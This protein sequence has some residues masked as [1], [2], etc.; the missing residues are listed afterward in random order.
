[1]L[2]EKWPHI[3]R[4][5]RSSPHINYFT[6]NTRYTS[7]NETRAFRCFL[8]LTNIVWSFF[9][10]SLAENKYGERPKTLNGITRMTSIR[11]IRRFTQNRRGSR[12]LAVCQNPRTPSSVCARLF[13][14]RACYE[15]NI[16]RPHPSRL[17]EFVVGSSVSQNCFVTRT[18]PVGEAQS[19]SRCMQ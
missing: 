8:F 19:A 3:K 6:F 16:Q 5:A 10:T 12:D 17:G 18:A 2:L 1:M 14:V 7:T 9:V 4:I 11:R 13:M 15:K